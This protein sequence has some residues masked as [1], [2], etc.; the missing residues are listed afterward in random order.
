MSK[1]NI[2][3]ICG[4]G[5]KEHDIS[6]ISARYIKEQLEK[7]SYHVHWITISKDYQ[8]LTQNNEECSL[9][10][11][12]YL[13][14]KNNEK[15]KIDFAIP[16]IHGHLGETG[17]I[18]SLFEFM[19]VPYLGANAEASI[20]CFNKVTTKLWLEKAGLPVVPYLIVQDKNLIDKLSLDKFFKQHQ[21]VFVKASN[22]GSSVGCYLVEDKKDLLPKIEEALSLSPY[23]LIEQ[24]IKGRELEIAYYQNKGNTFA[25]YPGEIVVGAKFYDYEEKYSSDSKTKTLVKAPD[26]ND[27]IVEK[28][29]IAALNAGR[30]FKIKHMARVDFFID[31]HNFYINEINTFP[32]HTSISMFPMMVEHNGLPYDQYLKDIIEEES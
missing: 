12:G 14:Y 30:L 29:R 11:D 3:L 24:N 31:G 13:R 7:S 22:Q 20:H 17:D 2:L 16:C 6:L 1:K 18:Q 9:T 32:G 23:V 10:L 4:G 21:S 5:G 28:M 15:V 26:L 25:T 27:E 8:Y 19:K